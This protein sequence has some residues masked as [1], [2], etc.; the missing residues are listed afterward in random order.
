MLRRRRGR[1][2]TYNP[3][4]RCLSSSSP[5]PI[6]LDLG[7]APWAGVP[8]WTG[9]ADRWA[10]FTVPIAYDLRYTTH[11]KPL[12]GANQVSRA[13]VLK[14]AAAR[15]T[16]ADWSTGRNSR[17]TNE[18]LAH[19]TGLSVRTV[20][21]ADSALRLLGVATEILRGRQRTYIE[22]MASWRVGDHGRGW[23]SVWALHD[24][25]FV[26]LSPHPEGSSFKSVSLVFEKKS[27]SG[28]AGAPPAPTQR[29]APRPPGQHKRRP[30]RPQPRPAGTQEGY[31]LAC[32]WLRDPRTPRWARQHSPRGWAA[33]LSAPAAAQWTAD[34]LNQ[35]MQEWT[36]AGGHWL[37]PRPYKPI[38]LLRSML[39]WHTANN[40]L[41]VRPAALDE[42]REAEAR[43]H[44]R[45]RRAAAAA[46]MEA[47][48]QGRAAGIAALQGSGRREALRAALA[49]SRRAASKRVAERVAADLRIAQQVRRARQRGGDQ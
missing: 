12:L 17:P 27:I 30:P 45:D 32:Q 23:A 7:D 24:S 18:R 16:Y 1:A 13:A 9:R 43:A 5:P 47:N 34:D 14:V 19:D 26:T 11:V 25:T 28:G 21:R 20:Q 33:A 37:P 8:C 41:E 46:E 2:R 44:L 4:H 31:A 42:A 35:L 15:T 39:N 40:T 29:G 49:I 10:R 48:A 36:R 38:G 6:S 3:A 22:R